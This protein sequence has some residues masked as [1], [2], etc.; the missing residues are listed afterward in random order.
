ML[1]IVSLSRNTIGDARDLLTTQN[2]V[3]FVVLAVVSAAA[4][5]VAGILNMCPTFRWFASGEEPTPAQRRAAVRIPRRQTAVVLAIW[6]V[7]GVVFVLLNL[8]VRGGVAYVIGGAI[9]FGGLTTTC[10]GYLITQRMP[11]IISAAMKNATT[12]ARS[13]GCSPDCC[14]SGCCSPRCRASV[15]H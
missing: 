11:P 3:A 7:G 13:P 9:L 1:V 8:N 2:L 6:A 4:D 14:T 12:D 15:S 5:A 10:V